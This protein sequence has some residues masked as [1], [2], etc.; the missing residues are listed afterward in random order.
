MKE[1]F[2]PFFPLWNAGKNAQSSSSTTSAQP[3]LQTEGICTILHISFRA[4]CR[5]F[6]S[7]QVWCHVLRQYSFRS[8]NLSVSFFFFFFLWNAGKNAQSSALEIISTITHFVD[9][10]GATCHAFLFCSFLLVNAGKNAQS[11]S[12]TT[13]APPASQTEGMYTFWH[14]PFGVICSKSMSTPVWCHV[15]SHYS[16]RWRNLFLPFF[17]FWNAGKNAQSSTSATS[18][19][20]SQTEGIYTISHISFG[21]MCRDSMS[22]QVWCHVLSHY[23]YRW[24]NLFPPFFPFEIQVKTPSRARQRNLSQLHKR[25]VFTPYHIF[26]L[27]PCVGTACER[28][29][30]IM[31]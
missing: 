25:K 14:I 3:A 20:A 10:F 15:L 12:S 30:A 22:T 11:C 16:Y 18:Q 4:I 19:P 13:S 2:S 5:D 8:R 29:F 26:L 31:F 27:E 7:T 28:K 1:P 24:R 9:K 17:S 23:S 21:A 6:M